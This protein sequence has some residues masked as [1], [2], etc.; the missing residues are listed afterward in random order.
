MLHHI[1]DLVCLISTH[2]LKYAYI[3][4]LSNFNFMMWSLL[5][6]LHDLRLLQPVIQVVQHLDV[7]SV[8]PGNAIAVTWDT[9]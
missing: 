9:R 4:V 5:F 8:E 7:L 6:A 1:I 3:L 2:V